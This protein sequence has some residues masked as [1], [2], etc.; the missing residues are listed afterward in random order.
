MIPYQTRAAKL[1]GTKYKEVY[2]N[3]QTA[4]REIKNKTKRRPYV[5]S[6]YFRKQ[7]I[8]FDYF[9]D[10]LWRTGGYKERTKRLKYFKAAIEVLERS[11]NE[12]ASK[13]N[14]NK[15]SEILHRF[16]G[17]TK[18]KEP[19]YVQVKEDKPTGRKYFMFCFP[20]K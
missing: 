8:F 11:K 16:A 12:P 17:L 5:R 9:W 7:K 3:A 19:F 18:N 10:H 6:S 2:E 14:P 20:S 1:P 4:F 13:E 15:K